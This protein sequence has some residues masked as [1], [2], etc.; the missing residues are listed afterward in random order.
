MRSSDNPPPTTAI[1]RRE[2]VRTATA[3]GLSLA[4][5][6]WARGP[7]RRS[8]AYPAPTTRR[9]ALC[10][11]TH[12]GG[13]EQE[14]DSVEDIAAWIES[15]IGLN[16]DFLFHLGDIAESGQDA[17]FLGAQQAFSELVANTKIDRVWAIPGGHHDGL[18]RTTYI[19]SFRMGFYRILNN[20]SQWYTLKIGNNVFIMLGYF[21]QPG[22]WS[23][24]EY[25]GTDR[26]D[27]L[28]RNKL[29]WLARTL[30]KW[31]RRGCNIFVCHHFPL[32]HTNIYTESWANM[33]R[34][35]FVYESELILD[36]LRRT[37]DVVAWFSGHVHVDSDARYDDGPGTSDGTILDGAMRPDLPAHVH[38]ISVGDIWREHGQAWG[39]G[40]S[41]AANFRYLD[42]VEGAEAVPLQS[43]DATS[44]A[45]AA[46][47]LSSPG[48]LVW[49]Y[50]LPLAYP[51]TGVHEPIE[52]EQAWDVWEYSDEGEYQW[53]QD[54]EGLRRNFDGWIES[55]WD[56]WE[57]RDFQLARM[58]VDSSNP[59][60]LQHEIQYSNDGMQTWST[61]S[62]TPETLREMPRA[63]WVRVIT[64]I[65][66]LTPVYIRNIE[67]RFAMHR[68]PGLIEAASRP[69]M[70]VEP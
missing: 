1:T 48:G 13:V 26:A 4:V 20:T 51:L 57:K 59:D 14:G 36:L 9:I 31:D 42:L 22:S 32:H 46:M 34:D 25:G 52:Y 41:T 54:N 39:L 47:S 37:Q 63:R 35:R 69:A 5:P 44:N 3:A 7:V 66:T 61:R 21:A 49:E 28:N 64:A 29:D 24:G 55:R 53:Y 10:A 19:S 68:S 65:T 38:F 18:C 58:L 62:F 40:L 8:A 50:P 12:W 56:F 11:D 30:A 67:F 33:N 43:W 23:S 2:F 45:P 16:P 70:P 17:Q 15:T 6:A 27:L 60:A